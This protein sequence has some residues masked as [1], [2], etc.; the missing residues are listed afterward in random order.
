MSFNLFLNATHVT[1]CYNK[2]DQGLVVCSLSLCL[3]NTL[4][5]LVIYDAFLSSTYGR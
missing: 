5:Q 3:V 1:I 2:V 4:M